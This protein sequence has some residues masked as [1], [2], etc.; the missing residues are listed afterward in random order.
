MRK[1]ALAVIS[2]FSGVGKGT[3]V[4]TLMSRYEGYA[5]SISATTR[6]PR[7]GEVDGREYHF[8]SVDAFED[9]IKENGLIE[10]A[11]YCDNYYGTPRAFVEDHLSRG[12]DVILEIEIQGARNI[13]EQYPEAVLIFIMP[14]S[15]E[16]L[17]NRLI[18][19]GT[20]TEDVIWKRLERATEE[21]EGIEEYDYVFVNDTPENC[22]DRIHGLINS[23]H[24]LT[25][26]NADFIE[27]IRGEVLQFKA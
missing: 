7:T 18:G 24:A 2:G 26:N 15:G 25:A 14:P 10:H 9:L 27:K 19:R 23:R 16:E 17:K 4:K 20:E 5:L 3:V 21:A 8:L 6:A 12:T 13:R 1:G 11:K 22:A